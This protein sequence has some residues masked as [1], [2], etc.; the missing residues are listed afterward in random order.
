MF[1][2]HI[3]YGDNKHR[4]ISQEE[5]LVCNAWIKQACKNVLLLVWD[6]NKIH[7]ICLGIFVESGYKVFVVYAYAVE[8][9]SIIAVSAII[10]QS[11]NG[12][13]IVVG[14]LLVDNG[15]NGDFYRRFTES[16][17]KGIE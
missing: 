8:L 17:G 2:P 13:I 10:E 4:C 15:D 14:V 9:H 7:L 11:I 1:I 16:T 5:D 6:K 3:L 12:D